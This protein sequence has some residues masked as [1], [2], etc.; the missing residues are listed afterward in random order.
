MRA[1]I[2]IWL[3]QL[4]STFG[5]R[6]SEFAIRIW[7]W[8][9]TGQ[10]TSIALVSFFSILP[11]I[12]IAVVG[13]VVV[14]RWNRKY[15]MM[16]SDI[17]AAL[18]T[19][20]ILLLYISDR[21]QTEHLF[22]LAVLSG[23][24]GEL[25]RIAYTSSMSVLVPP[26]QYTRASSM[27]S[28]VHYGAMV[29]AP[30][31]AG[32]L[33]YVIGLA[34]IATM[35]LV[36]F[37]I[38]IATLLAVRIPHPQ[39]DASQQI[40]TESFW[41]QFR[42]GIRYL[43]DRPSLLSVVAFAALFA[44][45]HDLGGAVLTPMI[46]ARTD[47]NAKILGSI[48]SAAGCGGVVGAIVVTV[49]GGTRRRIHGYLLGI[50]GAGISK[51]IF[52]LG[53]I[54]LVW[55]PAQFFSSLHFP[56]LESSQTSILLSKVSPQVQG[57]IFATR[58]ILVKTASATATPLSGFLADRL[59][60]PAMQPDAFLAGIF[61]SVVGTGTGAG[62]ALLYVAAST[63]LLLIGLG[64]Y[65]FAPLRQVEWLLPDGGGKAMP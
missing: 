15:V 30:A 13:G 53:Q 21:L 9:A 47:S 37:A 32:F 58:S 2:L 46:L 20:A 10:A 51:I 49:W 39:Q 16:A 11:S 29:M 25:Q 1:F 34:G 3:G 42:L 33:Y 57:R 14:D 38:A 40:S 56:L 52:G 45:V 60:E 12:A 28:I 65:I 6:A 8:E 22:V 36:T 64:G 4:V 7:V 43:R 18:S 48:A 55:L 54:P 5:T 50:A 17:V 61:G 59:L 23:A 44:F 35:D 63:G 24:F 27:N 41:Q 31:L 19:V 62:M 26:N